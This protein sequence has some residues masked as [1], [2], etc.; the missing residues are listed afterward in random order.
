MF[1]REITSSLV[2]DTPEFAGLE[3][4][5]LKTVVE[6]LNSKI[7]EV[8]AEFKAV[9]SGADSNSVKLNKVTRQNKE[10]LERIKELEK[11]LLNAKS[12]QSYFET[13]ST[14][15]LLSLI[16][17]EDCKQRKRLNSDSEPNDSLTVRTSRKRL[18]SDCETDQ[19]SNAKKLK[20]YDFQVALSDNILTCKQYR[21]RISH[22]IRRA[23]KRSQFGKGRAVKNF[24]EC[25]CWILIRAGIDNTMFLFRKGNSSWHEKGCQAATTMGNKFFKLTNCAGQQV[26]AGEK[27]DDAKMKWYKMFGFR[28][29]QKFPEIAQSGHVEIFKQNSNDTSS[30]PEKKIILSLNGHRVSPIES[31]PKNEDNKLHLKTMSCFKKK[32]N[33]FDLTIEPADMSEFNQIGNHESLIVF[34]SCKC[35]LIFGV[36]GY[37]NR[38]GY[39]GR[40]RETAE[41][42]YNYSFAVRRK[43]CQQKTYCVKGNNWER[44]KTT[45]WEPMGEK[46]FSEGNEHFF[47]VTNCQNQVFSC[48][49][50]RGKPSTEK[51]YLGLFNN[52]GSKLS[53]YLKNADNFILRPV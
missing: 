50:R 27:S 14:K 17:D 32:N 44:N 51:Y 12:G 25:K 23:V 9:S 37:R 21:S 40:W 38:V 6:C 1:L 48:Y 26:S 15:E 52:F 4:S 47:C 33:Q 53:Q 8:T 28:P 13:E 45:D 39:R 49:H 3:I 41:L 46:E 20:K 31:T 18:N 34:H 11:E 42:Q 36:F 2:Q 22:H 43:S 10:Y 7:A 16:D 30:L 35:W 5:R 29:K 19:V 24:H